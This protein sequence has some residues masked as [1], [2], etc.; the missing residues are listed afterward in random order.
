MRLQNVP[1]EDEQSEFN[2]RYSRD[3]RSRRRQETTKETDNLTST[4]IST[5]RTARFQEKSEIASDDNGIASDND[6]R[7]TRKEKIEAA[8][9]ADD[10]D[11][12]LG[13]RLRKHIPATSSK[14]DNCN[15]DVSISSEPT[16]RRSL[17]KPTPKIAKQTSEQEDA[18]SEEEEPEEEELEEDEDDNQVHRREEEVA[19][20][21]AERMRRAEMRRRPPW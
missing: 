10:E 15:D 20:E 6:V 11:E 19:Q 5:R 1:S 8:N 9:E 14:V 18:N 16:I 12:P 2:R 13:R 4:P 17:R 3:L 21:A 7:T